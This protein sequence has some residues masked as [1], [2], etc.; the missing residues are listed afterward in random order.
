MKR[1]LWIVEKQFDVSQDTATWL[2]II[3]NLQLKNNVRLLTGYK[4]QKIQTHMLRNEISY[5]DSLNIPVINRLSAFLYQLHMFG[6]L[7]TSFKPNVVIFNTSNS[8]LIRYANYLRKKNQT[9]LIFDVRTLPVSV[10]RIRRVIDNGILQ[11]NLQYSSSQFDGITYITEEMRRYCTTEYRLGPHSST[12]WTSGVN[13]DIFRPSS[14]YMPHD[15]LCLLYHGTITRKRGIHNVIKA[16]A[17]LTDVKVEFKILSKK[18]NESEILNYA[19]RQGVID[20]VHFHSEID[21][22]KV[23]EWI[24][25]GDVGILPF[26][27][28]PGWNTSSPIKLFEYLACAKPVIVTRIPAHVDVLGNNNFGFWADTGSPKDLSVAIRAVYDSRLNL[29]AV[30]ESARIFVQKEYTWKN[31]AHK[32]KEFIDSNVTQHFDNK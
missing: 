3:A 20:R 11:R 7:Y 6:K 22:E 25:D 14:S 17:L 18:E 12:I 26:P 16:L 4:N 5:Y 23:P 13:T 30:G 31:Q 10:G 32:L 8:L 19:R 29:P 2:E 1:I 24:N 28:W 27:N 15:G 9:K 21:Y